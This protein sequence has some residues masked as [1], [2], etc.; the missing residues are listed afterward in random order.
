MRTWTTI[1]ACSA[2]VLLSTWLGPAA[3]G[4]EEKKDVDLAK[5]ITLE[6]VEQPLDECCQYV[7]GLDVKV[8]C[9]EELAKTEITVRLT[10]TPARCV[11]RLLARLAGAKAYRTADG[12]LRISKKADAGKELPGDEDP[13]AAWRKAIV[14]KL[15]KKVNFE[16]V[17]A[18]FSEALNFI[19]SVAETNLVIDP[20]CKDKANAQITL[21]MN[22]A[23]LATALLWILEFAGCDYELA[24]GALFIVP[25]KE[26]GKLTGVGLAIDPKEDQKRRE[27]IE[28]ALKKEVSLEFVEQPVE[29]CIQYLRGLT[30]ANI[31]VGRKVL[32][33]K[34]P[35]LRQPV[36]LKIEK[37]ALGEA[38]DKLLDQAGLRREYRNG[39][40]FI[41]I[42]E[43]AK[44]P[45]G[46]GEPG[47]KP[48]P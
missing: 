35:V 19:Q 14:E 37:A 28:T 18:P 15:R 31:I 23:D 26:S 40:V 6:F 2:V 42:K 36:T 30:D 5:E 46:K 39:A 29:E 33:A 43:E 22:Q 27:A 8:S 4:E 25:A 9:D 7:T 24:D 20:A 16:F 21:R 13:A 10:K 12:G 3:A 34:T 17:Q 38:L 45:A 11:L 32:A 47:P 1:A 44:P 41:T 48:K